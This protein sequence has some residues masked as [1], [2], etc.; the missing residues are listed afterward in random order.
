[1]SGDQITQN[2]LKQSTLT[3]FTV[4]LA[5]SLIRVHKFED[6]VCLSV[7]LSVS[8]LVIRLDYYTCTLKVLDFIKNIT[9]K[10]FKDEEKRRSSYLMQ[11]ESDVVDDAAT[12][13]HQIRM[14]PVAL[15]TG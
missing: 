1:M 14:C 8:Q 9:Y 7:C 3:P 4:A 6:A 11:G 5:L 2:Q 15:R 13:T 10:C 12:H